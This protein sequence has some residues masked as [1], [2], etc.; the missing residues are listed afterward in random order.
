MLGKLRNLLTFEWPERLMPGALIRGT[1][2][3]TARLFR[4]L[5]RAVLGLPGALLRLPGALLRG[6]RTP[7]VLAGT[8]AAAVVFSGIG[9]MAV[10]LWKDEPPAGAGERSAK[11]LTD[12][13]DGSRGVAGAG[14]E[15]GKGSDTGSA[16]DDGNNGGGW[17]PENSGRGWEPPGSGLTWPSWAARGVVTAKGGVLVQRSVWHSGPA[18]DVL[19]RGEIAGIECKVE[20]R[21]V[22]GNGIWFKLAGHPGFVPARYVRN[23]DGVKWC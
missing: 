17:F 22:R 20:G 16:M 2:G 1:L 15:S 13:A 4:G 21:D 10:G 8:A 9:F 3:L 7:K 23:V 19:A 5:F 18:I 14:T 11:A 12:A 6:L